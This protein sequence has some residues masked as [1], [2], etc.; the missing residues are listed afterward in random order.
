M[1]MFVGDHCCHLAAE[2]TILLSGHRNTCLGRKKGL[3]QWQ[4]KR[5]ETAGCKSFTSR[6]I[7][8]LQGII[9]QMYLEQRVI[10]L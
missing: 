9:E 1:R 8:L 3:A 10:R 2:P 7:R 4:V 5:A 6:N